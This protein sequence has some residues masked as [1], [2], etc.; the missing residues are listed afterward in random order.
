M[1]SLVVVIKI[2]GDS[3]LF[4]F[5]GVM[6]MIFLMFVM[7][8]GIIFIKI[9]EGY[10]VVFFGIYILVEFSVVIFCFSIVLFFL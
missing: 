8:V 6:R 5:G 9:D 4:F 2:S 1:F 7:S 10:V 3:R